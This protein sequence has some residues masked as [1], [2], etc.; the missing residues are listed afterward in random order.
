MAAPRVLTGSKC[1]I[2]CGRTLATGAR[3]DFCP[4]CRGWYYQKKK[5][6]RGELHAYLQ[7]I[8]LARARY[9]FLNDD[10]PKLTVTNGIHK[11]PSTLK[12]NP[13]LK[14][15]AYASNSHASAN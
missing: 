13:L 14:D 11:M 3:S 15:R 10:N 1:L 8:N 7:R 5:K 6:T 9:E 12:A 4:T 2:G